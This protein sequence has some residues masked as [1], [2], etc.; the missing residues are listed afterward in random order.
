VDVADTNHSQAADLP[1]LATLRGIER[2]RGLYIDAGNGCNYTPLVNRGF[3]LTAI[4][5]SM[6]AVR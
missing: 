5:L 3:D 2:G 4:D 6:E 1:K